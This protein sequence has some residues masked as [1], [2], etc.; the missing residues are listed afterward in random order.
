[1][2]IPGTGKIGQTED[3]E[4]SE[5]A[6]LRTRCAQ[7]EEENRRLNADL[8]EAR[9]RCLELEA[10]ERRRERDLR[11]LERLRDREVC[12]LA[13]ALKV[14]AAECQKLHDQQERANEG[15]RRTN[16]ARK[17]QLLSEDLLKREVSEVREEL[18][19]AVF[20]RDRLQEL[21]RKHA[22]DVDE[23]SCS[24]GSGV[25][26]LA[27]G[28]EWGGSSVGT[29]LSGAGRKATAVLQLR[30]LALRK[31]LASTSCFALSADDETRLRLE[32]DQGMQDSY[33]DAPFGANDLPLPCP[34]TP[35][36]AR[37]TPFPSPQHLER[38]SPQRAKEAG[39]NEEDQDTCRPTQ[40]TQ[41][42]RL[43]QLALV[44]PPG[45]DGVENADSDATVDADDNE[46]LVRDAACFERLLQRSDQVRMRLGF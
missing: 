12:E 15:R 40:L 32:R 13:E 46:H 6:G 8:E 11:D 35:S 42:T 16:A 24:G 10:G 31:A 28:R 33:G 22:D 2:P 17:S 39:A 36:D 26:G 7:F 38:L 34:E 18:S 43:S 45:E 3:D 1:L 41:L 23:Q 25:G 20:E 37:T 14:Q 19:R 27:S 21:L 29:G 9:C 44:R 30:C 4:F 5:C